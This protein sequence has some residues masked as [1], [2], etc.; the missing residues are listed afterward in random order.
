VKYVD[1]PINGTPNPW[2]FEARLRTFRGIQLHATR[3]GSTT[4]TEGPATENWMKNPNNG[5]ASQGWGASCD[6]IIFHDG[7]RVWVN[8]DVHK[9]PTYGAG[10]GGPGSWSAGWYYLQVEIAQA[11]PGDYYLGA[12]VDSMAELTAEWSR[13]YGFAIERIPWLH[14]DGPPPVGICT[15][16]ESDNGKRLGKSDPGAM[17]PWDTYLRLA[18]GYLKEEDDELNEEQTRAIVRDEYAKL[19]TPQH[20]EWETGDVAGMRGLAAG[21]YI[22]M[23]SWGD[24]GVYKVESG[25]NI[26]GRLDKWIRLV[27]YEEWAALP[28]PKP[29]IVDVSPHVLSLLRGRA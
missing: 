20:R 25:S 27:S 26:K 1:R 10:Y 22:R 16:Q 18:N 28:D 13:R 14:Q 29:D 24:Q 2:L 12:E 21:T 7:T 5:S 8:S 6:V 17:W 11:N 3:G 15:H 9:A 19:H 23:T 4:V